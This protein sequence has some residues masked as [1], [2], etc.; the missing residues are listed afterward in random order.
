MYHLPLWFLLLSLFFPRVSLLIAYFADTLTVFS[1]T[2]WVSPI[3]GVFIPRALVLILIFQDRGMSPW[4][5]VHAFTMAAL[6]S[7]GGSSSCR[8]RQHSN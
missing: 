2:T 7:G 5:L 8:R 4:L 3:L 6:Y 1:L